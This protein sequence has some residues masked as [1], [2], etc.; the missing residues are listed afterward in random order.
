MGRFAESRVRECGGVGKRPDRRFPFPWRGWPNPV[1]FCSGFSG[2]GRREV[3]FCNCHVGGSRAS[4]ASSEGYIQGNCSPSRAFGE[5]C[6][7][8]SGRAF[9]FVDVDAEYAGKQ[10]SQCRR[11]SSSAS[12]HFGSYAKSSSFRRCWV[13]AR[14][15][16]RCGAVCSSC[17][18]LSRPSQGVLKVDCEKKWQDQQSSKADRQEEGRR[19]GRVRGRVVGRWWRSS[20]TDRSCRT[21][22]SFCRSLGEVDDDREIVIETTD[23]EPRTSTTSWTIRLAWTA[24][25]TTLSAQA[26]RDDKPPC[27]KLSR[28]VF[29]KIQSKFTER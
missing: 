19:F 7:R 26:I 27:W 14:A 12:R 17:W 3:L 20:F 2:G 8:H 1:A 11:S 16:S 23:D 15:R 10:C 25:L 29:W 28:K 22:R 18:R 24:V 6:G 4:G 21:R 9:Q 5:S 13:S